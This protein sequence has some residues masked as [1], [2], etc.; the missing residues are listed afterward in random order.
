MR[1]AGAGM[2]NPSIQE[3][4][5]LQCANTEND[6]QTLSFMNGSDYNIM[7]AKTGQHRVSKPSPVNTPPSFDDL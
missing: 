2:K 1:Q 3:P 5:D 7:T 4:Q 6:S